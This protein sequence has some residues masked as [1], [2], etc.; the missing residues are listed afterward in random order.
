VR[1]FRCHRDPLV[2]E[3]KFVDLGLSWLSCLESGQP[4]PRNNDPLAESIT[5]SN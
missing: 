1:L 5:W 2:K 3:M 4:D